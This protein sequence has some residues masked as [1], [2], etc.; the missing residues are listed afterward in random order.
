L[1]ISLIE[2]VHYPELGYFQSLLIKNASQSPQN[3]IIWLKIAIM[4][5]F[6]FFLFTQINFTN[7]QITNDCLEKEWRFHVLAIFQIYELKFSG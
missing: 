3:V 4:K 5:Y 7:P 1:E 2:N 6:F